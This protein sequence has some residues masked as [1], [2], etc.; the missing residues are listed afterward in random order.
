MGGDVIVRLPA[1]VVPIEGRRREAFAGREFKLDPGFIRIGLAVRAFHRFGDDAG[2]VT[3]LERAERHVGGVAGHI[4]QGAGAVIVP[5]APVEGEITIAIFTLSG[6]TQPEIPIHAGRDFS[7]R[8]RVF[9][10]LRPNRTIGPYMDLFHLADDTALDT[11]HGTA[12][13]VF[14]RALVAHLRGDLVLSRRLADFTRLIHRVDQRLLHVGM[15]PTLNRHHGGW[16]M[17]MVRG[18]DYDC[19]EILLLLEHDA[20]IS[21]ITGI[22]EFFPQAPGLT[23]ISVAQGDDVFAHDSLGIAVALTTAADHTNLQ[24]AGAIGAHDVRGGHRAQSGQRSRLEEAA[25]A[26]TVFNHFFHNFITQKSVGSKSTNLSPLR[27]S[28][29]YVFYYP[30]HRSI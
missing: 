17:G 28:C 26:H 25:T 2:R 8:Q 9:D 4:A 11:L 12:Q 29:L 7:L 10:T 22:G 15:E 20:K 30:H 24:F 18:G 1:A 13:T 27:E 3:E 21:V 6:R 14:R 23:I 5:A 16:S 19:I